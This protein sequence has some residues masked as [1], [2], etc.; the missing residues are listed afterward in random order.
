MASQKQQIILASGMS[1]FAT[2]KISTGRAC[3]MPAD[4]ATG[5]PVIS[6]AEEVFALRR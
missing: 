5:Y 3:R 2:M 4:Y 6:G 1:D